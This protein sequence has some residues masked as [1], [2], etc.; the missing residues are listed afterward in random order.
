MS[1][2]KSFGFATVYT[3]H[4]VSDVDE[5]SSANTCSSTENCVNLVGSYL[6][7]CKSG[8]SLF[9]GTDCRGMNFSL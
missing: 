9:A 8:F 1:H 7:V 2:Y 6:C 3:R 5:C 4:S